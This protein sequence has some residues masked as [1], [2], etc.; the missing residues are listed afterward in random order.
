M[1]A[2]PKRPRSREGLINAHWTP[3]QDL[4][5]LNSI[6]HT[7]NQKSRREGPIGKGIFLKTLPP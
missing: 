1:H 3:D 5:Q 4:K 7:H 2:T 6:T